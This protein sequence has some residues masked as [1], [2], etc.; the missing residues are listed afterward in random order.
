MGQL[1]GIVNSPI[2]TKFLYQYLLVKSNL[3][4]PLI[5][6]DKRSLCGALRTFLKHYHYERNHQGKHNLLLLP[7]ITILPPIEKEKH[8]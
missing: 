8:K 5:L 4:E 7:T 2:K 3:T 6:F 1:E